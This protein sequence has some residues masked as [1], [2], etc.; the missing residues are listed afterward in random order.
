[1]CGQ[2]ETRLKGWTK[3]QDE[4]FSIWIRRVKEVIDIAIGPQTTDDLGTRG[5]IN[6]MA[7]SADGYFAVVTHADSG[8]LTPDK[9]PP[10]T[11][12]GRAQ[13]GTFLS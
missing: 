9:R 13:N 4:G 3:E 5:C 8:L 10:R 2:K 1:M 11:G 7:L 6:R 12:W